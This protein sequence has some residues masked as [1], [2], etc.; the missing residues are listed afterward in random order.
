MEGKQTVITVNI[1]AWS[2]PA[3]RILDLGKEVN[4]ITVYWPGTQKYIFTLKM[5]QKNEKGIPR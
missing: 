4:G 5:R 2:A 3:P 1:I